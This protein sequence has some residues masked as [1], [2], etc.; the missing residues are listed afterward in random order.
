MVQEVHVQVS[1]LPIGFMIKRHF[2]CLD[3]NIVH[4]F[5]LVWDTGLV[6]LLGA[7]AIMAPVSMVGLVR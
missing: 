2:F 1:L 6:V 3:H 4:V 7:Y 5:C